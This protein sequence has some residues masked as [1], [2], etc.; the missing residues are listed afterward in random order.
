[1][2]RSDRMFLIAGL[3]VLVAAV[4]Y[5]D[6]RIARQQLERARIAELEV[7]SRAEA[8]RLAWAARRGDIADEARAAMNAGQH[9]QA[10]AI[11]DRWDDLLGAEERGLRTAARKL[12]AQQ[13]ERAGGAAARPSQQEVH[14]PAAG[15]QPQRSAWDGTYR[16]V[17]AWVRGHATLP[18]TVEFGTCTPAVLIQG[19]W[20][21]T[22]GWSAMNAMGLRV[23]ASLTFL[24]VDGIIVETF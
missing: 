22:C 14:R 21:T 7:Q 6:R 10:A 24:M 2:V 20:K 15:W 9:A 19:K 4:S 23:N 3:V 12:A 11:L 5:N 8:R 18:D 16:E 1:M 17:V 13:G